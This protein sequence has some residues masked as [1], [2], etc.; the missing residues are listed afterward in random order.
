VD[1]DGW[2]CPRH[3]IQV[4]DAVIGAEVTLSVEHMATVTGTVQDHLGR[5]LPGAILGAFAQ[6]QDEEGRERMWTSERRISDEH[7]HYLPDEVVFREGVD[8]TVRARHPGFLDQPR[9]PVDLVRSGQAS[10]P[11][12]QFQQPGAR[13]IG[14]LLRHDGTPASDPTVCLIPADDADPGESVAADAEARFERDGLPPGDYRLIAWGQS[15]IVRQVVEV[16]R[17]GET[18]D[19]GALTLP[20]PSCSTGGV[21]LTPTGAPATS[22]ELVLEA[23]EP[24]GPRALVKLRADEEGRYQLSFSEAGPFTLRVRWHPEGEVDAALEQRFEDVRLAGPAAPLSLRGDGIVWQF[25]G[26]DDQVLRGWRG[27]FTIY[28]PDEHGSPSADSIG[29]NGFTVEGSLLRWPS[30]RRLARPGRWKFEIAIDG[31]APQTVE[32]VIDAR[33]PVEQQ[34]VVRLE[35]P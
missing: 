7:G 17:A 6:W 8:F 28:P 21:I 23:I 31:F 22:A 12:I 27:F 33:A 29:R 26:P 14:Q 19:L 34:K 13:I 24:A 18:L 16:R 1:E 35:R 3:S 4:A 11:V 25:R 15:G 9:V 32:V 5:P 2:V 10:A 20:A 30:S